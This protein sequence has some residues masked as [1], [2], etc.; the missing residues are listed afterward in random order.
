MPSP[1]NHPAKQQTGN[2]DASTDMNFA[3]SFA[4]LT[5]LCFF[6]SQADASKGISVEISMLLNKAGILMK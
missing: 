3:A 1:P 2:S 6:Y 4:R 5:F